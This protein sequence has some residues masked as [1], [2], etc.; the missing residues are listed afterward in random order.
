MRWSFPIL[1]LY[2]LSTFNSSGQK[3]KY[4]TGLP[5][6]TK[7]EIIPEK[8]DGFFKDPIN[9][10][11]NFK[12]IV[13]NFYKDTTGKIYILTACLFPMSNDTSVVIEYYKD[14]SDF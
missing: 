2:I 1:A 14:V 6:N 9:D 12:K 11:V 10:T 5:G 13:D 8:Y 7:I 4:R 3:L